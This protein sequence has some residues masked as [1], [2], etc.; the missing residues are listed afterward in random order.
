M[1]TGVAHLILEK[2]REQGVMGGTDGQARPGFWSSNVP[3]GALLA[4]T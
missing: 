1:P 4:V 3:I 2:A